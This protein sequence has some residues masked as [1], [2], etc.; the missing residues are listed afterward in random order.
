MGGDR[1]TLPG[2]HGD[3]GRSYECPLGSTESGI[4]A[5]PPDAK[6]TSS[7]TVKGQTFLEPE[8]PKELL[9]HFEG[10]GENCEFGLMQRYFGIEPISLFRWVS[11]SLTDLANA[12]ENGL[13]GI[14]G[15]GQTVIG[16]W[17]HE[18]F[19][20][21]TRYNFRCILRS[22]RKPWRKVTFSISNGVV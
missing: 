20:S 2:Q 14:G 12:V 15:R 9:K 18:Y 3:T 11:I 1:G 17:G 5:A 21:D 6:S 22:T 13:E 16:V 4:S 19:V 10:L 8:E 7:T